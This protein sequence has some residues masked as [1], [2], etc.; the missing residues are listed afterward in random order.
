MILKERFN[1]LPIQFRVVSQPAVL[2]TCKPSSAANPETPVARDAQV[3][4][5]AA[6]ETLALWRLPHDIPNTIEA[7]QPEFRAEPEITIGRLSN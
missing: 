3:S 7:K 5:I 1:L 6:G 4:N 2:P